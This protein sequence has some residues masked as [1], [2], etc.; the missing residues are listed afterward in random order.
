MSYVL[1]TSSSSRLYDRCPRSLS[2]ISIVSFP[3]SPWEEGSLL[4][5]SLWRGVFGRS[6]VTTE[7]TDMC[8]E[9]VAGPRKAW[10]SLW[11][12]AA[13]VPLK[14]LR[15]CI[16]HHSSMEKSAGLNKIGLS[17]GP[18]FDSGWTPVNSNQYGFEQID[19]KARILNY[20]FQW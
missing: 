15:W 1:S 16:R 17:A 3:V 19:P 20:Y 5:L 13:T 2:S 10:L 11:V 8:L 18:Q 6:T 7:T 4:P 12:G 14:D 9:G